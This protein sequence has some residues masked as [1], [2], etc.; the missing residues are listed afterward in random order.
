MKIDSALIGVGRWGEHQARR[1][2]EA[3]QNTQIVVMIVGG[4]V[5]ILLIGMIIFL[6][7]HR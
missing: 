4:T 6:A 1:Y 7:L 3:P 2:R 5:V